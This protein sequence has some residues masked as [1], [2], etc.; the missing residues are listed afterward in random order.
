MTAFGTTV[1][2]YDVIV[3]LKGHVNWGWP[4]ISWVKNCFQLRIFKFVFHVCKVPG[5]KGL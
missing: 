4:N 1:F 5:W 2:G 3:I